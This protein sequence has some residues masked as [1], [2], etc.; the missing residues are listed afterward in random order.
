MKNLLKFRSMNQG[1]T[2]QGDDLLHHFDVANFIIHSHVDRYYGDADLDM[3]KYEMIGCFQLEVEHEVQ[4]RFI[5]HTAINSD[6]RLSSHCSNSERYRLKDDL[7]WLK[8]KSISLVMFLM[9]SDLC[10]YILHD[11]DI[12]WMLEYT[13]RVPEINSLK[14]LAD[15]YSSYIECHCGVTVEGVIAAYGH[16]FHPFNHILKSMS[17]HNS[18]ITSFDKTTEL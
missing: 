15:N 16:K 14:L 17:M 7:D 12:E 8:A 9:V 1:L 10:N 18:M 5:T 11:N 6:I 4:S 2:T 3:Y 13:A